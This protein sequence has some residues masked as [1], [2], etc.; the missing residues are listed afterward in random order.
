MLRELVTLSEKAHKKPMPVPAELSAPSQ[1]I[2][3][4]VD[5]K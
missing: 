1:A 2:A 3:S 5:R 4:G